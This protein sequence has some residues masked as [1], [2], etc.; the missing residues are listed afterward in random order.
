MKE[1]L[2]H[3]KVSI[4]LSTMLL[5]V[6]IGL[7]TSSFA[8]TPLEL[9]PLTRGRFWMTGLPNGAVES[10]PIATDLAY[11]GYFNYTS[12]L[13]H[14]NSFINNANMNPFVVGI[15]NSEE[16]GWKWHRNDMVNHVYAIVQNTI[17]KN[18]NLVNP[19]QAEEYITA[20]QKSYKYFQ[21]GSG[22]R[23]MEFELECTAMV[24]SLPRYDD[25]I[26]IKCK[27]TNTDDATFEDFYYGRRTYFYGTKQG[28]DKLDRQ[29]DNEYLWDE[30]IS[31]ELGFVFYDD[32]SWPPG[33]DDPVAYQIPPG[34][35]SGDS[36]DPGNILE[37]NSIDSKLY[38]PQLIAI[39][40]VEL[41]PN[42]FG[43][44][45][46]WRHI[47]G[48]GIGVPT[49]ELIPSYTQHNQLVDVLTNKPQPEKSWQDARADGELYGGSL[50]EREPEF[51]NVI[52]PYN[53]NP[54]ESIEWIEIII[55]GEMERTITMRGGYEATRSYVEKGL[56]N[57]KENWESAK[58]LIANDFKVLADV[59]PPTP[60]DVPKIGNDNELLAE[61]FGEVIDDRPTS[62]FTL[63]WK[64]VHQNYTDPL[65]GFDDFAGYKIY[66]SDIGVEGPWVL[67]DSL[68]KT[69]AEALTV[70][71]KVIFKL[72]TQ[73]GVPYRLAVTS[74]DHDGNESGMTGYTFYA[75]SAPISPSNNLSDILV[76]PNPFRQRSG[77]KD[78][79]E[80]KRLTFLNVPSK[81]TIR[82]Y[83]MAGNMVKTISHDG[84]GET[85][86]GSSKGQN[87][88]LT[89]F[90]RNVQPGVYIYHVENFVSGHAGEDGVGKFVIIK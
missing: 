27:L 67:V 29:Y 90:G 43:E 18:Y 64:A 42:K 45:K 26:L 79:G 19:T 34:D 82:I 15:V 75:A 3:Q 58:E 1:R 70:D 74:Y 22:N 81:C 49:E 56:E 83:N 68:S 24:W 13:R 59:P 12:N 80:F 72:A 85:T 30:E 76:V 73:A 84:G 21:D 31:D 46:V 9:H 44:K 57:L 78:P 88:M 39:S 87:Y 35:E 51:F 6:L 54:G 23:H 36:G 52:G 20:V 38:S 16:V 40:F 11:P 7:L 60:A 2:N 8:Q 37:S 71:G 41:T 4:Y 69:E 66:Q 50:Y 53:I 55:G 48:R 5:S 62:G 14:P 25:F 86:W 89:D 33:Y 77:F 32:T 63:T 17:T 10:G 65:T 47:F 28:N 61:P